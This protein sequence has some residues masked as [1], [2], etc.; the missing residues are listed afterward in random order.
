MIKI[1]AA[2]SGALLLAGAVVLLPGMTPVVSAGT[3]TPT[4]NAPANTDR[5]KTDRTK[6]DRLDIRNFGPGCSERGW[7][8][9]DVS[10]IRNAGNQDVKKVRIVTTD[11]LPATIRFATD[12]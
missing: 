3:A 1:V 12:R 8:Y 4:V 7:P 11:R 6:T 9:Y 5:T 2:V 10:C